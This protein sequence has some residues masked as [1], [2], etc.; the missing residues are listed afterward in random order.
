MGSEMC[1]RDRHWRDRGEKVVSSK[2]CAKGC[3]L[4]PEELERAIPEEEQAEY[5]KKQ[6]HLMAY[7]TPQ[8]KH[9][10]EFKRYVCQA[11]SEEDV[12]WERFWEELPRGEWPS[13][14]LL[15]F[16]VDYR[17]TRGGK[18]PITSRKK[19]SIVKGIWKPY[20]VEQRLP[21]DACRR[22]FQFL[23]CLLYTSPSPR[24]S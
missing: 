13:L 11:D 12:S 20:D 22:A 7:V 4:S 10:D 15:D 5:H 23:V 19:T 17:T 9:W 24:D 6:K 2:G 8:E 3:D 14:A 1:I 18:A 21:S 16:K